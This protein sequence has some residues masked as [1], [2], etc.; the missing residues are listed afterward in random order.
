MN[1]DVNNYLCC[2]H[3]QDFGRGGCE[4]F[5]VKF[6]V[7]ILAI[8]KDCRQLI[9]RSLYTIETEIY[10]EK[11]FFIDTQEEYQNK[12]NIIHNQNKRTW[13]LKSTIFLVDLI[14]DI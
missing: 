4:T 9:Y 14:N 1:I 12:S 11:F 2:R 8:M 7:K 6:I 5:R 3:K 13:F 10:V